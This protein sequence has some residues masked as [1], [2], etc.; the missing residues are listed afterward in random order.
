MPRKKLSETA[1]A[2]ADQTTASSLEKSATEEKKSPRRRRTADEI[3]SE[4][5]AKAKPATKKPTANKA[6]TDTLKSAITPAK[7]AVSKEKPANSKAKTAEAIKK[8]VRRVEPEPAGV[9]QPSAPKP[10]TLAQELEEE[11][12]T[13]KSTARVVPQKSTPKPAKALF[14]N[15]KT[16]SKLPTK[17]K[18]SAPK[19][20]A[21]SDSNQSVPEFNFRKSTK[22]KTELKT[23]NRKSS[24]VIGTSK[25]FDKVVEISWRNA[26]SSDSL[27]QDEEIKEITPSQ[28]D[29]IPAHDPIDL[30]DPEKRVQI[31]MWRGVETP[32]KANEKFATRKSQNAKKDQVKTQDREESSEES[33][34]ATFRS[35][36]KQK[37]EAEPIPTPVEEIP[38]QIVREPIARREEAAQ[39]VLH[40]GHPKIIKNKLVYAP[41]IFFAGEVAGKSEDRVKD[42]FKLASEH[43]VGLYMLKMDLEVNPEAKIDSK[44]IVTQIQKL[45]EID[46]EAQFIIRINFNAPENWKSTYPDAVD[47][48]ARP[49]SNRPSLSDDLFW[50]DSEKCLVALIEDLNKSD[51]NKSIMGVHLD[52]NNWKFDTQD[53]HDTSNAAQ[54]KFRE[55]LRSRYRNDNVTLRA[56]W[57]DG[58]VTFANAEIPEPGFTDQAHE[59]VRTDRKARRWIDY[60]LF[61]SDVTVERIGELSYAAKSASE[62]E[63]LVG[64]TYGSTFESSHPASGQLSLGKLLRCPELDYISGQTNPL[65]SGPG[66]TAGFPFPVDSFALNGKLFLLEEKYKTPI[67]GSHDDDESSPT[68]RTPQALDAAHWRDAGAALAHRGGVIW[69]DQDAK[70]WLNSRGIWE[71]AG[72]IRESL[73]KN[74]TVP[75]ASAE[76]A[77]FIDERSLTYLADERSFAALV[78]NVRESVLRSGLSVGFY[79]LSDLAHRE[80]FPESKLYVFVNAWDMR[81]EVRS[82]IK[83]RLQ[84]DDKVLFWLYTAGLFESGRETLERVREVTGIALRPQPFNSKSG[85]TILNTK[86]PLGQALSAEEM[87]KGCGLEPSYFAIP[88][89][90][91]VIAEYTS[92]GLASLIVKPYKAEPAEMSWTSVFLGEPILTPAFLRALGQMA[93]CHVWNFENDVVHAAAPSL[94]VHCTETGNRTFT[95]PSK[96]VAYNIASEEYMPVE[97]NTVRFKALDG[98]TSTFVVGTIGDVQNV[99]KADIETNRKITSPIIRDENTLK[100][101]T[102]SFD[103]EIMRLDEWVE[104]AWSDEMADDLLLK[105]SLLEL[106]SEALMEAVEPSSSTDSSGRRR[107]RK[108]RGNKED[109][110]DFGRESAVQQAEDAVGVLFRKRD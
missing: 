103:V 69:C 84:R 43:G 56:S 108:R 106:D 53:G 2:E 24:R 13:G 35:K 66:Q 91:Q 7:K 48:S 77:V 63:F 11:K 87:A 104:E 73:L 90:G 95:L 30:G 101:D 71:R 65:D 107:R 33:P 110:G 37:A 42:Q 109:R 94:S 93:G 46:G 25:G 36:G 97:N 80:N 88:E 27:Q 58:S 50:A 98:S 81:P 59:F 79:L 18:P 62:G 29:F 82:A 72:K 52:R 26:N 5:A 1:N 22:S 16:E 20:T 31:L 49:N 12:K 68:M 61:L 60:H 39:V 51:I 23:A 100:W 75:T 57:F 21:T 45:V 74:M 14:Q 99:I 47:K 8:P 89:D 64:V 54:K 105:P 38:K 40:E 15:D 32:K 34:K 55:W 83:S 78:Q 67:S 96:W 19:T 41:F 3:L 10:K 4:T 86:D 9:K 92:T 85:T 76:V 44:S 17:S 6:A 70:G 102:V 28:Q